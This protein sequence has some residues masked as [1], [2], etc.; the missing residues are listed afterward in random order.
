MAESL[1]SKVKDWFVN[2][3]SGADKEGVLD[4]ARKAERS[5]EKVKAM[6]LYA[7]SENYRQAGKIAEELGNDYLAFSYYNLDQTKGFLGMFFYSPENEIQKARIL[8]RN[9][10]YHEAADAYYN[11]GDYLS[12]GR[13][14]A[15]SG[16]EKLAIKTLKKGIKLNERAIESKKNAKIK[17][18]L[19]VAEVEKMQRELDKIENRG[20]N[21]NLESSVSSVLA[22]FCLGASLLF[23]SSNITG[24]VIGNL[25]QPSSN[26]IGGVLFLI[27]LME[28]FFYFKRR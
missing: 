12:S 20:H 4:A 9:G 15:K 6:K 17:P 23:L 19:W 28:A 27:G 5:G 24:N 2:R 16:D 8:E 14:Y 13:L 25:N 7:Q 3:L 11:C 22:I 21:T 1:I 26:L 18:K 10:L